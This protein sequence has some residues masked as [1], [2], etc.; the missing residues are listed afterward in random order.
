MRLLFPPFCAYCGSDMAIPEHEPMICSDCR[1]RLLRGGVFRCPR[2]A[3]AVVCPT[4]PD[5]HCARCRGRNL[6]FDHVLALGDYRDE[7][8]RAVLRM[9]HFREQ[10][11]AA[12]MGGLLAEAVAD[13][14]PTLRPD[15]LVSV[16]MYWARRLFRKSNG[17]EVFLDV[18]AARLRLPGDPRV[19]QCRRNT[20]KQSMLSHAERKQ[21]VRGAFC[22]SR[23]YDLG[24][25]HIL[26]IDDILT[27]GATVNEAAGA[28][29]RAGAR[30]V[31]VAVIARAAGSA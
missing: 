20:R 30:R 4:G 23:G 5:G 18:L 27:T 12:A 28:L 19:L 16:P 3:A 11:L 14:S 10:P 22:V 7:L 29:R 6:R 17:P 13:G 9:K 26:L 8:R 24:G 15:L 1:G 2:C 31:S 21:N 25:A